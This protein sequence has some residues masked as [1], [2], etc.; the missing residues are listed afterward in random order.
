M[1]DQ[2]RTELK[3]ILGF[4]RSTMTMHEKRLSSVK[5]ESR[6]STHGGNGSR[7]NGSQN[8]GV[9]TTA[10]TTTSENNILTTSL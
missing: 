9:I 6:A 3:K 7:K 8:N 5:Q 4:N 1:S 10:T 2:F